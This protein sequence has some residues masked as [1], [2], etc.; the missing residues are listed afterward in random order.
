MEVSNSSAT[1]SLRNEQVQQ[2]QGPPSQP[3]QSE[4]T[5]QTPSSSPQP[6]ERV[7][8]IINTTA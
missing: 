2:I 4:S 8:S 3:E 7:G 6:N 1:T 5:Q